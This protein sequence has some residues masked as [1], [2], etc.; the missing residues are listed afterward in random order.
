MSASVRWANTNMTAWRRIKKVLVCNLG[1][2]DELPVRLENYTIQI[3]IYRS[4]QKCSRRVCYSPRYD[5][6]DVTINNV[7]QNTVQVPTALEDTN[8]FRND[9][10]KITRHHSVPGMKFAHEP[11]Y[12]KNVVH[13][14]F[15]MLTI[16]LQAHQH[17]DHLFFIQSFHHPNSIA[18]ILPND[19]FNLLLINM[20]ICEMASHFE[21]L[22]Y[23]THVG[24]CEYLNITVVQVMFTGNLKTLL[25]FTIRE[26]YF[27]KEKH[28][29]SL[30]GIW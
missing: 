2:A 3:P 16:A 21:K 24:H 19:K 27:S 25:K 29:V 11:L 18:N 5:S 17:V 13:W 12:Q 23:G 15:V 7:T 6:N 8:S 14:N 9:L 22:K 10:R 28:L 26:I 20:R 30:M 4:R 1:W